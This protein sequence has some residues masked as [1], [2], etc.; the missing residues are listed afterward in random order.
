M[1]IKILCWKQRV[2]GTS[3]LKSES[4]YIKIH[5]NTCSLF[6]NSLW[7]QIIIVLNL[8]WIDFKWWL[9]WK[10]V[11]AGLISISCWVESNVTRALSLKILW[12]S[13][14][15]SRWYLSSEAGSAVWMCAWYVNRVTSGTVSQPLSVMM[16][17]DLRGDL[18]MP[19]PT[20]VWVCT[21]HQERGWLLDC[22][23]SPVPD[24]PLAPETL[25]AEA[26]GFRSKRAE[27]SSR[28]ITQFLKMMPRS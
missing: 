19:Y 28:V 11:N 2:L 7:K 17:S 26:S 20:P 13:L 16:D 24:D 9:G 18:Q 27:V 1:N 3:V 5:D 21:C 22:R 8:W 14:L 10:Q 15:D 4:G 25:R 12:R 6:K 23:C